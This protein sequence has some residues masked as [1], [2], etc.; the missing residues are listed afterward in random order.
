LKVIE[1]Q[2]KKIDAVMHALREITQVKTVL[3]S[4]GGTAKMIDITQEIE[5]QLQQLKKS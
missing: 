1:D 4:T 2:A 5:S 3:Y